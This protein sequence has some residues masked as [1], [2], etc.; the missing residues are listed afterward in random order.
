M[1]AFVLVHGAFRGGWAWDRLAPLLRAHG[2]TV[3]TPTLTGCE[4]DSA[5]VGTRVTLDEWVDDVVAALE[6]VADGGRVVLVGHSQG[7]VVVKAVAGLH[8]ERVLRAV[9]VDAPVPVDGQR[10]IDLV[11]PGAPA[12]PPDLDPALWVPARP[13][14]PEE[15]FEDPQVAAWVNE[16]LVPTPLGPSLD[17]SPTGRPELWSLPWSYL[18]CSRTPP[19]YPCWSTRLNLDATGTDYVLLDAAHDVPLTDPQALATELLRA[20]AHDPVR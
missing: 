11:P 4:P 6:D 1:T 2:H 18:Y 9:F 3:A 17:P 5:R 8:P 13:V 20:V 12:A 15:G 7:G 19:T 16:R 14:G 10:A